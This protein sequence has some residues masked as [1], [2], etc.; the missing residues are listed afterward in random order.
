M[1]QALHTYFNIGDISRVQVTGLEGKTYID[2]VNNEAQH[3]QKDTLT[4]D[5]EVD[6]VYLDSSEELI[7]IDEV[8]K[9][10]I[11]I[12]REGSN[13]AVI[14]NPWAEKGAAFG[15]M[16][17]EGYRNMLCVETTNAADD[18]ITL[19]PGETFT[20]SSQYAIETNTD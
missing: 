3:Q 2:K 4:I 7:I 13:S 1:S 9:R 20:Q 11:H 18:T 8:L 19:K 15:D 17:E 10:Q 6:R 5:S 16:G 14:W 12:N